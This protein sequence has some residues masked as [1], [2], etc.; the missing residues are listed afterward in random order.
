MFCNHNGSCGNCKV[1]L[2]WGLSIGGPLTWDTKPILQDTETG[3]ASLIPSPYLGLHCPEDRRVCQ[4]LVGSLPASNPKLAHDL[5]FYVFS[6]RVLVTLGLPS[7]PRAVLSYLGCGFLPGASRK[8]WQGRVFQKPASLW[9]AVC[10]WD[11]LKRVIH[12]WWWMFM[13]ICYRNN[14]GFHI[15]LRSCHRK[16]FSPTPLTLMIYF[17][18]IKVDRAFIALQPSIPQTC[19]HIQGSLNLGIRPS[20]WIV[21]NMLNLEP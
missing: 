7:K 5:G 14:D 19:V 11:S 4:C 6:K 8:G 10:F 20:L 9:Q 2:Q 17:L 16:A 21:R 1:I 18:E 13:L 15:F 12:T 3:P